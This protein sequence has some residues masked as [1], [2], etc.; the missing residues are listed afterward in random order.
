MRWHRSYR[1]V[2]EF[3]S[4][5]SSHGSSLWIPPPTRQGLISYVYIPAIFIHLA[6]IDQPSYLP[7][8]Q[9]NFSSAPVLDHH[10]PAEV[11][12]S[13]PIM[14]SEALRDGLSP[15]NLPSIAFR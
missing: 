12:A 5:C 10:L 4:D 9:H 13:A 15:L 14:V 2:M 6:Y 1:L 3:F 11:L 8:I 7:G